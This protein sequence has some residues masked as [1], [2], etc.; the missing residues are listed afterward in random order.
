MLY[1]IRCAFACVDQSSD[2]FISE[3]AIVPPP[4]SSA[5][6]TSERTSALELVKRS[7][8][9]FRGLADDSEKGRLERGFLLAVLEIALESRRRN[10]IDG[11]CWS[12]S[13][14][15][16]SVTE[17]TSTQ[18]SLCCRWSRNILTVLVLKC[19]ASTILPLILQS[20]MTTRLRH[21]MRSSEWR[22]RKPVILLVPR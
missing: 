19:A 16:L 21:C 15:F 4:S 22:F 10:L 13:Y 5:E 11:Q 6:T 14:E 2:A 18:P 17:V 8:D 7:H 9:L 12:A 3:G 20:W 1:L